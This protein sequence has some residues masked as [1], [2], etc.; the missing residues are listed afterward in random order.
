MKTYLL[1]LLLTLNTGYIFSQTAPLDQDLQ[2]TKKG[3]FYAYWGWNRGSFTK[4]DI[5]FSGADYDFVLSDAVAKDKPAPFTIKRYFYP[6]KA[7]VPQ[8][9][10]RIGYYFKENWDLSFGVDHMKY[11]L[12]QDQ[13]ATIDGAIN[14]SG[15]VY[16]GV[17]TNDQI[18]ITT[19][20]LKFEHTDGL[21]Y[22]NFELRHTDQLLDYKNLNISVKEGAGLGFVV[23]K[24]NTKLLNKERY[25]KYHITGYGLGGVVALN[26]TFYERFF[27]QTEGKAGFIN[28]PNIRTTASKTDSAN[29]H[30]FF[31][32]FNVVFGYIFNI[33]K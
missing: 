15:T 31:A 8:Y 29:Q 14:N 20:F 30:F 22:M 3:S 18:T 25:D 19:D 5:Q 1:L 23:T 17:Y 26:L 10:L 27:I 24:T 16:D 21:N 12:Q 13:V 9:N 11:V 32:Q 2:K 28:L 4:S 6:P 7:T 33:N